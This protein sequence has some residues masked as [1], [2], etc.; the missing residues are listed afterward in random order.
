MVE[1][2]HYLINMRPTGVT[3]SIKRVI[4]SQIPDLGKYEDIS[5]YVLNESYFSDSEGEDTPESRV[6]FEN[7]G[8]T[9]QQSIRLKEIGPR[10]DLHLI[11][12]QKDFCDGDVLFH[13]YGFFFLKYTFIH[14][15]LFL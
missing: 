5:D 3:K 12:V 10:M 7:Q 13:E 8:I 6:H 15:N 4:T 1:F 11:K 14:I 2:R 9:Q